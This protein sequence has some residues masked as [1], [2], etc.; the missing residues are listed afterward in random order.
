MRQMMKTMTG[1]VIVG[2]LL[3]IAVTRPLRV[4]A[5]EV[6]GIYTDS[7]TKDMGTLTSLKALEGLK[8]RGWISTYYL[9]NFNTPPSN[10][11]QGQAFNAQHNNFTMNLAEIEVEKVPDMGGVGFKFD[12]A[13]GE[14]M[15]Y[16]FDSTNLSP[17]PP[18]G[19]TV[20]T[21]TP[22]DRLFQH[23]SVSYLAPL[24]KG[25]RIDVGKFVTHI[26]GETIEA[27]KN[28]NFSH[29]YFYA[30]AIPFQDNGIRFNYNWSDTFY[31]ELY[32]LNGWNATI[33][34]QRGKS[35]GPSLG[36][37]P[38]PWLSWYLN[39]LGGP[40]PTSTPRLFTDRHLVDSQVYFTLDPW[41]FAVNFDWGY[42][43]QINADN[44][45]ATWKSWTV[46]ARYK[47]TDTI[48]PGVRAEWYHDPNCF[49]TNGGLV[50]GVPLIT[51]T[52]PTGQT[53]TDVTLTVSWRLGTG[54]A[55][56]LVRPEVRVDTS[57][58][59]VFT[60]SDGTGTK[61]QTSAGV[62]VIYYF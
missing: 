33:D 48:E 41:N 32:V 13:V 49:T 9:Y 53:L 51:C 38:L 22:T 34:P 4:D 52:S 12:L 23:A 61:T 46:W 15:D 30:Y 11:V 31:T 40:E 37:T 44:S 19:T 56:V 20:T 24:G 1:A 8:V 39:Y 36:W 28:N 60:K 25:L 17:N 16:I 47:V 10:L 26:G 59:N 62:N 14:T 21:L 18:P 29:T 55:H 2:V 45:P 35:I 58:Q 7:T 3:T 42:Q 57:D 54:A 43:G 27:I 50:N 6:N 5:A